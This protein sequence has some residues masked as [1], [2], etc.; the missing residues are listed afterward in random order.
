MVAIEISAMSSPLS[1]NSE[2]TDTTASQAYRLRL[3]RDVDT[4]LGLLDTVLSAGAAGLAYVDRG[5][6]FV[7]ANQ[8]LAAANGVKLGELIGQPVAEIIGQSYWERIKTHVDRAF[9][10]V[11]TVD[12]PMTRESRRLPGAMRTGLLSFFP[13]ET[14]GRIDGV[15]VVVKDVT[16]QIRAENALRQSENHSRRVA[17]SAQEQARFERTRRFMAEMSEQMHTAATSNEVLWRV[18]NLLGRHLKVSRCAYGEIDPNTG[19]IFVYKDYC[20]RVPS[21][22]GTYKR[23]SFGEAV[24]ADLLAGKTVVLTNTATDPR[25]AALHETVYGPLHIAASINVPIMR[26]GKQ[27][28]TLSVQQSAPREWMDDEIDLVESV[29]DATWLS[30]DNARL[31]RITQ[32]AEA[33]QRTFVRDIL[34]SVTEGRLH[35]CQS[36]DD[37]PRPLIV[38]GPELPLVHDDDIAPLRHAVQEVAEQFAY[39]SFRIIDLV[40]ATGEAAMNAVVHAARGR[41]RVCS[42]G[43]DVIQVWIE[44]N[45]S[46]IAVEDLPNATLTLGYSTTHT[47]GHGFKIMLHTADRVY[48]LTNAAGTTIVLEQDRREP[49]LNW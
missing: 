23:F 18:V 29:A 33:R 6:R 2:L 43:R 16:E 40:T 26:E 36:T 15:V 20:H 44:D 5:Y 34:A 8:W 47:L 37:L 3:G 32:Q 27:V 45:G 4:A 14:D 17:E 31:T 41:G 11:S 10:G 38:C 13:A 30:V 1:Q 12:A 22:A 7:Y 39:P 21:L 9:D 42:D 49:E 46:G 48:L 19:Q 25:T 28:A 35:L 24:H